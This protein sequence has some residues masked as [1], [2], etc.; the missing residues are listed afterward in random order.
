MHNSFFNLGIKAVCNINPHNNILKFHYMEPECGWLIASSHYAWYIGFTIRSIT[1]C[2]TPP[3][4]GLP[5]PAKS[6]Y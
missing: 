4:Q 1:V 2:V 5:Y 6:G 3:G